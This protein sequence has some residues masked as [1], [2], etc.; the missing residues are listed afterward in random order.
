[1]VWHA[2]V[3]QVADNRLNN[4]ASVIEG[5][6]IWRA[7]ALAH[8]LL[9]VALATALLTDGFSWLGCAHACIIRASLSTVK[10]LIIIL[11]QKGQQEHQQDKTD[12]KHCRAIS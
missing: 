4:V 10:R 5:K 12:V 6:A 11:H 1:M 8:G 7:A 3:T 9:M 2:I